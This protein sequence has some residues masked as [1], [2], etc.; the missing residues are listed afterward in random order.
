MRVAA[1]LIADPLATVPLTPRSAGIPL[2]R[3]Q[4]R[5]V[6]DYFVAFYEPL[7]TSAPYK[8]LP[9][10]LKSSSRQIHFG[11]CLLACLLK[12]T[13]V[14]RWSSSPRRASS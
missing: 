6:L 11:R 2:W 1:N 7:L 9:Q 5:N 10:F 3:I 13:S 12:V 4:A 14:G 8:R